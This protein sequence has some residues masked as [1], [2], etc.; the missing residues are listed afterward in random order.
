[1]AIKLIHAER[2]NLKNNHMKW[3]LIC[4]VAVLTTIGCSGLKD[5]YALR[6]TEP[7]I[8]LDKGSCSGKCSV[9]KLFLYSNR[10]LVFE[11]IQNVEM[12]G[13]YTRKLTKAQYETLVKAFVAADFF[14]F[15]N[16]YPNPLPELPVITM[17]FVHQEKS[18]KISGS[19]DRPQELLSLQRLLEKL[20]YATDWK[21]I[22][23]F[24]P[25][26]TRDEVP[27]PTQG[28]SDVIENQIIIE[29]AGNV[30]LAQWL[31]KYPQYDIQLVKRLSPDLN[32]WVITFS[33]SK[34]APADML[35]LLKSDKEIK[36]AEFNKKGSNR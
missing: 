10:Q 30:F 24:E 5:V 9:Y 25:N 26:V 8:S 12:Y 15:N 13:L 6:K 28:A 7:V 3:I 21:L 17:S 31:K 34:I 22:K 27:Q 36:F 1:M 19:I 2:D 18:K 23:A 4:F 29:P 35:A 14:A 33:K 20:I 11:G 16:E 32:Y